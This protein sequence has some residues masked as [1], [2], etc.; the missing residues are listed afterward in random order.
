MAIT[1]ERVNEKY[2]A[3]ETKASELADAYNEGS[4]EPIIKAKKK[5]LTEAVD[6][7]N[8]ENEEYYYS[9]L[10]EK[11]GDDALKIGV[12]DYYIPGAKKAQ[13]KKDRESG[14]YEGKIGGTKIPINLRTFQRLHGA[15]P[16]FHEEDWFV[17]AQAFAFIVANALNDDLGK[18][19]SFS[20]AVEAAAKEFK[21]ADDANPASQSSG[22]KALQACVDAVVFIELQNSG[23]NELKC[24]KKHWKFV[25]EAMTRKTANAKG[26]ISI[27]NTA[28][29]AALI[30]ELT[31]VMLGDGNVSLVVDGE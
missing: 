31:S 9:C 2:E 3:M 19:P 23:K 4:S 5:A 6:A 29:M 11:H 22:L 1:K 13:A 12:R 16:Y 20:Y 14:R 28:A 8:Q 7:Y 15:T 24:I 26:K 18:D 30:C 27:V 10:V 21:F 25:R 17:K